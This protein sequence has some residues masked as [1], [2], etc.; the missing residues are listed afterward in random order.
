MDMSQAHSLRL[1][2]YEKSNTH[3]ESEIERTD[4]HTVY[5]YLEVLQRVLPASSSSK[6]LST[7]TVDIYTDTNGSSNGL[8]AVLRQIASE[9]IDYI[10]IHHLHDLPDDP[11]LF[12][13]FMQTLE[14]YGSV[15]LVLNEGLLSNILDHK[16][17]IYEYHIESHQALIFQKTP[18]K[19]PILNKHSAVI[20]F[21]YFWIV[22]NH[23]TM[24]FP[25]TTFYATKYH[26]PPIHFDQS[27]S[28]IYPGEIVSSVFDWYLAYQSLTY[29]ATRLQE[30]K[31]PIPGITY[32]ALRAF[33]RETE[34]NIQF[35]TPILV[36]KTGKWK[37]TT[38]K[39]I[40]EN[41]YYTNLLENNTNKSIL[42][43]A[44]QSIENHIPL[45]SKETYVAVKELL[46]KD[47]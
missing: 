23:S 29:V 2:V 34:K 43:S 32:Q 39:R 15:L 40:L 28:S 21:G 16:I 10:I 31:I 45:I 13:T 17:R 42:Q 22:L 26:I 19:K 47:P 11:V 4:P 33:F 44:G 7:N 5:N 3:R 36:T 12:D 1:I 35:S 6:D 30:L 37:A 18:E 20:P 46:T 27:G 9:Q 25:Y 8:S 24:I 38:V 41:T 14:R